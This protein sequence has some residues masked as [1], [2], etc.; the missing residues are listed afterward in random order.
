MASSQVCPT[1]CRPAKLHLNN[2]QHFRCLTGAFSTGL[3]KQLVLAPWVLVHSPVGFTHHH[4]ACHI[5]HLAMPFCHINGTPPT[6][7]A[8]TSGVP[9]LLGAPL[10][11]L[12]ASQVSP[13][14]SASCPQAPVPRTVQLLVQKHLTNVISLQRDLWVPALGSLSQIWKNHWPRANFSKTSSSSYIRD[15]ET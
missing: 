4:P 3:L 7:P 15:S 8:P 9:I 11:L 6:P 14:L 1:S 13:H 12:L 5:D 2:W 10:P